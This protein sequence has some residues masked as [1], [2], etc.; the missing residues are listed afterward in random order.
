VL[1]P[2]PAEGRGELLD[3]LRAAG[4]EVAAVEAYRTVPARAEE[5]ACLGAW[6]R[7]G[8]ID[9]VAFASPSAVRAV[10]AAL[11]AASSAL[12]GVLLAAIGPS[13]AQALREVDLPVGVVAD[14]HTGR[15]L[16]EAIAARLGPG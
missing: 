3:G 7:A 5:L 12:A 8:E 2:R 4:A 13:T 14:R 10:S 11:G 16:A 9:A 6:I 1:V 15:D